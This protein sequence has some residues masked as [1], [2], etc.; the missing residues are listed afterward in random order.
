MGGESCSLGGDEFDSAG[1]A[2]RVTIFLDN[3][4]LYRDGLAIR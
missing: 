3:D 1:G 2:V 4:G